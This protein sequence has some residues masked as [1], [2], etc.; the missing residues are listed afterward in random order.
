MCS[1]T[2]PAMGFGAEIQMPKTSHLLPI[3]MSWPP[4]VDAE[5]H[6]FPVGSVPS[7][8][9]WWTCFGHSVFTYMHETSQ[10]SPSVRLEQLLEVIL[11]GR[12]SVDLQKTKSCLTPWYC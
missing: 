3:L 11:G 2:F 7:L 10:I 1:I 5:E 9:L 8:A 4:A 12:C 6:R